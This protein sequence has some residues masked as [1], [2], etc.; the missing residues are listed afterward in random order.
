MKAIGLLSVEAIYCGRSPEADDNRFT[1]AEIQSVESGGAIRIAF[2]V[3]PGPYLYDLPAAQIP[4][5]RAATHERVDLRRSRHSTLALE[6]ADY[7]ED[8]TCRVNL[9][10]GQR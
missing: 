5:D 3:D 1:A 4:L 6:Q 7:F 10:D 9:A 2:T 8:H